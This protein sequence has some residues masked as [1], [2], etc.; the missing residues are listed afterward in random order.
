MFKES[1]L[2]YIEF[3]D[4][5]TESRLSTNSIYIPAVNIE[6][7]IEKFFQRFDGAQ[8]LE[9]RKLIPKVLL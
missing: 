1:S 5:C 7:A 4:D 9:A 3:C 6:D 2:F 8:I